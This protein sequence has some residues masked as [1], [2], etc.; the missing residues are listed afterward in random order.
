MAERLIDSNLQDIIVP[1]PTL[2]EKHK[3]PMPIV[4]L[5]VPKVGFREHGD[6]AA[7][8]DGLP[9]TTGGSSI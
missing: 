6:V 2:K 7:G 9:L 8:K 5:N 1:L 4:E 3:E